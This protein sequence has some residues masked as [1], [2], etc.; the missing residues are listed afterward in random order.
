MENG[1]ADETGRMTEEEEEEE[2]GEGAEEAESEDEEVPKNVGPVQTEAEE[3]RRLKNLP[4]AAPTPP[5]YLTPLRWE[6][7]QH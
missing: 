7:K 3:R 5:P 2:E 6:G 1:K 4:T